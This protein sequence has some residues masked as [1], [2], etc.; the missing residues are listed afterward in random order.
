MHDGGIVHDEQTAIGDIAPTARK[1]MYTIP[2]T[3]EEDDLAGVST[4][5]KSVP[6]G[7]K[8][9]EKARNTKKAVKRAGKTKTKRTA[10]SKK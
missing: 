3:T 4:L 2:V 10:R 6:G 7:D 9:S 1:V 5:M 8:P